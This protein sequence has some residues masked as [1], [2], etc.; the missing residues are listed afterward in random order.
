MSEIIDLTADL[1]PI[2]AD[3]RTKKRSR[4]EPQRM[5][6]IICVLDN[7]TYEEIMRFFPEADL[8][9]EHKAWLELLRERAYEDIPEEASDWMRT[10][11]TNSNVPEGCVVTSNIL[12]VRGTFPDY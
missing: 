7:D 6:C 1:A 2:A 11:S 12:D 8:T 5:V 3:E 4:E 9:A 10:W